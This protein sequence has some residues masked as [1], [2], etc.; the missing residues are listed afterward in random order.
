MTI[1]T[2]GQGST[3]PTQFEVWAGTTSST[4]IKTMKIYLDGVAVYSVN[5]FQIEG[6]ILTAAPGAH[7]MTVRAWDVN[8]N[9]FSSSV[10]FYA[11]ESAGS[12]PPCELKTAVP[13]VTICTPAKNATGLTSPV[14]ITAAAKSNSSITGVKV[15]VDGTSVYATKS[16]IVDTSVAMAEGT[17]KVT[18]QAW[19]AS[20][21]V[22][23]ETIYVTAGTGGGSGGG[24]M[25]AATSPAPS[26]TV[27]S[28]TDGANVT[29][30]V[31]LAAAAND[32]NTVTSMAVYVDG[33]KVYGASN[34][35]Q[36]STSLTLA[37]GNRR[38]TV[39]YWNSVGEIHKKTVFVNVGNGTG[40]S[41]C[42]APASGPA[43]SICSPAEGSTVASPVRVLASATDPAPVVRMELWEGGKKWYEQAGNALDTS[44]ALA[45]GAHTLTVVA[46]NSAGGSTR[47][48]VG[49][50][51]GSTTTPSTGPVAI[52][53]R[54]VTMSSSITWQFKATINGTATT[55][56]TWSVD[57]I[58][59]GSAEVGT[60]TASGL[61]TPPGTEGVH[62][63]KATSTADATKS[64]SATV[65]VT[66]YAGTFTYH[67]DNQR[68]GANTDEWVLTPDKLTTTKFGKLFSYSIDAYSFTQPLYAPGVNIPNVGVRNVVYVG[69]GKNT[70]YAFDAD[71]RQSTP[72][73][74]RSLNNGGTPIP[75][76]DA[77]SSN[78]GTEIGITGTPVIDP[79]TQTLYVV[80]ASKHGTGVYKQFLNAVDLGT[81]AHKAGSP[82]E[83]R[84]SYPGTGDNNNGAGQ[85]LWSAL[86]QNQRPA[87]AL[88]NGVVYIGWG[89]HHVID[90]WHGWLVG[91]RASDLTQVAVYNTTP[92]TRHGGIWM[93]GGA[94]SVDESGALYIV[95]GQGTF[96]GDR[97]GPDL[98][99]SVIKLRPGTGGVGLAVEDY[100]T[101]FNQHTLNIYDLDLGA[102]GVLIPP[103]QI[104]STT[105]RIAILGSKEGDIY[106]VNRD[107]LGRYNPTNNSQIVQYMDGATGAFRGIPTYW[108]GFVYFAGAEDVLKAYTLA[109]ARLS[110][111]V[112]RGST[113]LDSRGAMPVVSA[114]GTENGIVWLAQ[115]VPNAAGVL[116]AYDA[117]NVGRELWNSTL[118]G[119]RDSLGF[120]QKFSV[121]TVANGRVYVVTLS[122]LVVYGLL[123]N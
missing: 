87:L 60:I 25:C 26:V 116:R 3:V 97:G 45:S 80:S 85:V 10:T 36:I 31:A 101:P 23:R 105:P 59:G 51:V 104:G 103:Q 28:P 118:A 27:C 114:Q 74:T 63:V 49:F 32:A 98:G 102:S 117:N 20:G 19:D 54:T 44:L 78:N 18:V 62:T 86:R 76:G 50:T 9:S 64:A 56:V 38:I 21:A 82:V 29:S 42:P 89:S 16:S 57:G 100:F 122:R 46:V 1:C 11:S 91:Y 110:G 94:P 67:N 43:I 24:E 34:T 47:R 40:S 61:Y 108:N 109:N 22:F 65:Y 71:G 79:A 95:S 92:N 96:T 53:P 68:T 37:N 13:S 83:I 99:D 73:W 2:P 39:Q 66:N 90:P 113:V 77:Q 81:G 72:L 119:S 93:G 121:P 8:G 15:Y 106:V 6:A 7:R 4:A 123:P 48:S 33:A 12:E 107:S 52:S 111:P 84:A 120:A 115:R 35:R 5:Y 58:D 75:S 88:H 14:R 55:E 69:T 112:S 41:A 70:L 30:P 17:H